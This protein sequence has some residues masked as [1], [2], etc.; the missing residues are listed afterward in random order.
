MLCLERYDELQ[1]QV[2]E[3]LRHNPH[4]S[5]FHFHFA[6]S[7]GKIGQFETSEKH[8]LLALGSAKSTDNV[9]SYHANL[10]NYHNYG[11]VGCI[12]LLVLLTSL[13]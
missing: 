9:A 12:E 8:F 10:G 4:E 2:T 11:F 1:A 7:L 13:L 3:A 6:S 5:A